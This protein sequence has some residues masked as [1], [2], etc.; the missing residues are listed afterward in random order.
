M[1]FI[2]SKENRDLYEQLKEYNFVYAHNSYIVNLKYIKNVKEE[3]E[4]MNGKHCQF[5]E[6]GLQS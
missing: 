4:L 3:I 6:Q 5:Q 2:V 1:Y